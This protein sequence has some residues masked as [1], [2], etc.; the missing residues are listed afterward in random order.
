VIKAAYTYTFVQ[1][2]SHSC[3]ARYKIAERV[4]VFPYTSRYTEDFQKDF[5]KHVR[6][7]EKSGTR[8]IVRILSVRLATDT[9]SEHETCIAGAIDSSGQ[10][11]TYQLLMTS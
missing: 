2:R 9:H 8:E 6:V 11:G 10:R 4:Q 5:Q 3:R 7:V 1:S